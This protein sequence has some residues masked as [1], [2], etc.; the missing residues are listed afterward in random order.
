LNIPVPQ[1]TP[2]RVTDKD[3]IRQRLKQIKRER[4]Y[5]ESNE[6]N[7]GVT[8]IG[9]P[10]FGANGEVIAAIGVIGPAVQLDHQLEKVKPLVLETAEKISY[11]MGYPES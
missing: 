6:T 5:V 1:H 11:K 3:V 10:V 9:S 4:I 7:I 8:G 2:Y